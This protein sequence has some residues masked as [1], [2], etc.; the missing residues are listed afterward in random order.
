VTGST[1][2]SKGSASGSSASPASS[3][4]RSAC[5]CCVRRAAVDALRVRWRWLTPRN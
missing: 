4:L 2:G 3:I 5:H 1:L